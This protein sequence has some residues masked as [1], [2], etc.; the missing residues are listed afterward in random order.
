LHGKR[1]P[2]VDGVA[3]NVVGTGCVDCRVMRF[4]I[5]PRRPLITAS[6]L[7]SQEQTSGRLTDV[8]VWCGSTLKYLRSPGDI[9]DLPVKVTDPEV[10]GKLEL[11][12]SASTEAI[13]VNMTMSV[14]FY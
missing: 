7:H 1:K 5:S 11:G 12:R 9:P 10:R 14:L 3:L 6:K 13:G 4:H 2:E 8:V